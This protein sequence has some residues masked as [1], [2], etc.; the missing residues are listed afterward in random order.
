MF[1]S[2]GVCDFEQD[3]CT[4]T[5]TQLGDNFDWI[6]SKGS[7]GTSFT[8]PS[9][10][11]TKGTRDGYYMYL[12]TSAPRVT[13]DKA[14]LLSQ[15]YP[16]SNTDKCFMFYYHM[17]GSDIGNLNVYLLLNQS[18]DTFSTESLM[19]SLSGDWG[20]TWNLGQF[21]I[22]ADYAKNPFEVS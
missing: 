15:V 4:W 16:G 14:R 3:T 6:R 9:F 2:G 19:W 10:D 5:N 13:G 12:E 8:G 1:I 17:Y 21:R 11:H 20:N 22:P 18:S 7:T